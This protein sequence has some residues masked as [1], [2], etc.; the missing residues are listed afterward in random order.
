MY[1]WLQVS[2]D[3]AILICA[4]G[5]CEGFNPR[6]SC[7]KKRIIAAHHLYF[8]LPSTKSPLPMDRLHFSTRLSTKSP[9]P[10]DGI[11]FQA[12]DGSV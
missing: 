4:L 10:M 5:T 2:D 12:P 1:W 6:E 11:L 7:F 8:A 9:L 3:A